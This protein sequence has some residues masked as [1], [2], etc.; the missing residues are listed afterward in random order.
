MQKTIKNTFISTVLTTLNISKI[1][2][3][4]LFNVYKNIHIVKYV[5]NKTIGFSLELKTST[6]NI[7]DKI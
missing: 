6:L 1:M 2:F 4:F 5:K 3:L 7:F